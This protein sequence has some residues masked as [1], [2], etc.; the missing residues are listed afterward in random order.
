MGE[1]VT[2]INVSTTKRWSIWL[3]FLGDAKTYT[4]TYEEKR[5]E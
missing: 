3:G 5:K 4:V 1:K 2:I